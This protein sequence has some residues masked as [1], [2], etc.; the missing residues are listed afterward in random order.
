MQMRMIAK[1]IL[2]MSGMALTLSAGLYPQ[3]R[4]QASAP[5]QISVESYDIQLT[6]DPDPHEMKAVAT[7]KFKVVQ[8]TNVVVFQL[9]ENMSVVKVSDEKGQNLDFSQDD[10]GPGS[11]AIHYPSTRNAGESLTV[12]FEYNGGFDLDRYSRNFSRD[13]ANA[14]IGVEG[15]YLL[16]PAKWFPINKLF[17]DRPT[18]NIDVTV[19][20]GMTA[21]GPGV[22]KPIV[23]RD[24]TEVFGWSAQQPVMSTSI[25]AGRY[26]ERKTQAGNLVIDTFAREDH[27]EAI[28]KAAE[29]LAKPLEYYQQL[30][31]E[32]ASGK[33]FRLVEVDDRLDLEPGTLG[34]V[35]ITHRELSQTVPPMRTLA[36][37]AASQWWMDTIGVR[38][39]DDLWL[40]DGMAYYAA[41]VYLGQA[42][43]PEVMKDEIQNLAVLGLKY[44]S[45]SP[46][47][48]GINLGYGTDVYESVVAGKGAYILNM[49]QG[50]LGAAK[51]TDLLLQ[52]AKQAA[53]SGGSTA[54]FQKLAEQIHGKE[55]GWFFAE[56]IDTTGVPNLQMDYVIYKTRD[57]FRVSGS[58][59]QDRDLFRMPV[60]IEA[61]GEGKTEK[62]AI[63]L[64][65]KSTPFD[66]NTFT[67]P[68]KIT[69]D[70]ENKLLSDSDE[71]RFKVQITI[72]NELKDRGDYVDAVR[73]Y[74]Q[75]IKLNPHRSIAHF[76][77]AEVFFEQSNFQ[78]SSNT[79]REALN[80]D[81]EPRWVEVWCYIYIGKIFDILGQRQRALAEY[82]K[83]LNTKDNTD[84]AQD[85]VKKWLSAP[86]TKEGTATSRDIQ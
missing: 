72:G 67:W 14:Y 83:A 74:E 66:I 12:K 21:V 68:T 18:V 79:F 50:M 58:V 8:A 22:Q 19:P 61:Q 39:S 47:R 37:R 27:I 35:F 73:A 76:R 51:F 59:K 5:P 15:T 2:L 52:Y 34:T 57:G 23:T 69:I 11:I 4:R 49:L 31:G 25:V 53:G 64:N 17:G 30:W 81:K 85:E 44:E 54:G 40:A 80:G 20:L 46:V 36:R 38:S 13:A 7:V 63:E 86:F 70:P 41:A 48:A 43:G 62:T 42:N 82:N 28:R 24:V 56:W 6:L 55:L 1:R 78:A 65:G 45:K 33:S 77:L 26:F 71:L 60:E 9:S 75:A 16:Y 32:S 29:A 10:P 3:A 84:G